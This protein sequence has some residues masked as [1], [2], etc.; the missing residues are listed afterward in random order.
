MSPRT[1]GAL[2]GAG[3]AAVALLAVGYEHEPLSTVD[4]ETARWVAA[5]LPAVLEW[6]ARPFS[7]LGGW[8][9]LTALGLAAVA[10]LVR[11]RA[12]L[13]LGLLCLAFVGPQVVV[14]LL[15]DAF[16]RPR[17]AL[18]SAVPLPA[19][20]SFPSGHAAAGAA[21]LGAIAV[22]VSDRLAS[23]RARVALW[24]LVV[25]AGAGIGVSRV[26]LGV[27]YVSDVLA[28]WCLGLAWLAGCLLVRD[29]VRS[30]GSR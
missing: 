11:R 25:A 1:L 17:P 22:I 28:G 13:D 7:W 27:H 23:R 30:W 14:A 9:G 4:R 15:K 26:A 20:A 3:L 10:A 6:A 19:S 16:D 2:L 8:I 18:G 12:W 21:A 29:A 5:S 24:I